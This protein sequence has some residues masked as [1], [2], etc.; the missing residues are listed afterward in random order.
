MRN[1][2]DFYSTERIVFGNGAIGQLDSILQRLKAK[3]I[4]LVTDPGIKNAGIVD[5]ISSLLEQANYETV[6]YDQVVPEPPVDSAMDCYKFAKSQMDIDAVIGL[7][8]GS[9][10]DMAKIVALLVAHGGHPL[11][12]YGG[13]NQVPGPIAPLV[14][15]PT[16]AG[17]GS[18]V[19]S[20]AVLTD[21]ENNL[22][23]GIS[24]N[25]LRP[26]VALLDPELTL[27]LPA[28]V[29][30][31]SGIDALSHAIEAY[32]AKPSAYIQAEG[33][34]LFQGS[35]PISDALAY[36]AIELIAKNL[37]LAVQQGSNLEARSNMLMGSLLAGMSFSNAGTAAAHAL[38]YPIGG[39]VKSPHGEVTGLLL[40]Y[41]MEYNAAVETEKMVRIS[42]AFNVNSDGLSDK[43]AALAAS[44]AVLT[45]LGEIGLP[46]KLTEIGI[47]E[48][49]IPEIAEKTLQIDRLIRN[50][51][52]MP[53]QHSLEELLRKAL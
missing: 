6:I 21:V 19:T 14:A 48:E 13:E 32:T 28:Y 29:T 16:T 11:D 33:S 43:E 42:H 10:I 22:K 4:L 47:K 2:W 49:D 3:N 30:A 5:R 17:T 9:S 15:I 39:L 50:N 23:V 52:R 38:A 25:Y 36:R 7:G 26:T 27:G 12:Y 51:P 31:C 40:P 41:V 35:I 1:T 45:L 20:V 46:T 44:K 8:G 37:P 24:D 53:T 34:I 18:E